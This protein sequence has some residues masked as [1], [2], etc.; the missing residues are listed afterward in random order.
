MGEHDSAPE[1]EGPA[2]RTHDEEPVLRSTR[3]PPATTAALRSSLEDQRARTREL[4]A[5]LDELRSALEAG[6]GAPRHPA[7]PPDRRRRPRRLI[8][9]LAVAALVG[10]VTVPLAVTLH[11]RTPPQAAPSASGPVPA[12]PS[13]SGAEAAAPGAPSPRAPGG[14]PKAI[15]PSGGASP[16]APPSPSATQLATHPM[17]WPG[18]PVLAP[19]GL[20]GSG[21]GADAPGLELTAALDPD[22]RHVDVYERAVLRPGGTVLHLSPAGLETLPGELGAAKPVVS[23]LQVELDDQAA[24]PDAEG[25]GWAVRAPTGRA[26]TRLVLRYRVVGGL[27]RQ[28]PAPPG[29]VT[30]ILRPLAG[31]V[32][33]AGA[34]P[35]LVRMSDS[36]VGTV[37]CPTAPRPL[38]AVSDG[39]THTA[40]VPPG[41][42][43]IVLAQV[44]LG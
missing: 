22:A 9:A 36:R 31:A 33:A 13:P 1:G 27:V 14:S 15:S 3:L 8:V 24:R 43:A 19:P 35:V 6:L 25:T 10:L 44:N 5:A 30:L 17:A 37:S 4:R 26:I 42:S 12:T 7:P 39:Q 28:A 32:V 34:D 21:P 23:D 16:S 20:P 18:G 41:A 11:S 29:R 2:E 38:C 40:T